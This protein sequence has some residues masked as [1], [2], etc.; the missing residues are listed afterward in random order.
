MPTKADIE[1]AAA[2]LAASQQAAASAEE[3]D[4][5][6]DDV[7]DA[8]ERVFNRENTC[9][10]FRNTFADSVI[11]CRDGNGW[12]RCCSWNQRHLYGATGSGQPTNWSSAR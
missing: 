10:R 1:A 9:R 5:Q 12:S 2:A 6:E 8:G 7:V 3:D 4:E 11:C